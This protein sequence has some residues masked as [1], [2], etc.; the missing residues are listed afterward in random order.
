M[1]TT[2]F[3]T[4]FVK[5][6]NKVET[7]PYIPE[8]NPLKCIQFQMIHSEILLYYSP[9]RIH[10]EIL[11]YYTPVRIQIASTYIYPGLAASRIEPGCGYFSL[12]AS[13]R[14]LTASVWLGLVN[15]DPSCPS[16]RLDCFHMDPCC[17]C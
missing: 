4:Y 2:I 12:A 10:S 5:Y 17:V 11:L 3:S 7:C 15:L 8:K 6:S 16:V 1:T 14:T 13:T 9:V